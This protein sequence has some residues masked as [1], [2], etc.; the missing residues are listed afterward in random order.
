MATL[1]VVIAVVS[2]ALSAPFAVEPVEIPVPV[3]DAHTL[4][5]IRSAERAQAAALQVELDREVARG[6]GGKYFDLR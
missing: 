5:G 6:V 4:E 1:A 3:A 2:V